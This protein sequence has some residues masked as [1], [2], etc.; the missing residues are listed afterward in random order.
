MSLLENL[1]DHFFLAMCMVLVPLAAHLALR[2][3]KTSLIARRSIDALKLRRARF[4]ALRGTLDVAEEV[5]GF[6]LWQSSPAEG[7]RHWTDGMCRLFGM[8]PGEAICDSDAET[9]LL[10]NGIDLSILASEAQR[11]SDGIDTRFKI[12]GLDDEERY[13]DMRMRPTLGNGSSS[14]RGVMAVFRDATQQTVRERQLQSLRQRAMIEAEKARAE[15]NRDPLTNLANR[16]YLMGELDRR[17]ALRTENSEAISL[18]LFD[19]DHFKTVNDRYGHLVG[20]RVLK[21]IA[22]I[23]GEQAREGDLVGRIGG[24]EFV[25]VLE[26][27]DADLAWSASERLRRAIAMESGVAEVPPVTISVGCVTA[28]P[29]ECSLSLFARADEALYEAKNGGRNTVRIAA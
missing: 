28:E 23:A 26:G 8:N 29:G 17:L 27:G 20:D 3:Y 9:L 14:P 22:R 13:I 5:G 6:G 15:A 24:E 16:R 10:S 18:I 1:P 11:S 7:Q 21:R 12:L 2:L 4:N 19:V 25:W